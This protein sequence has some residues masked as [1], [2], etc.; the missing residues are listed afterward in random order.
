MLGF[1]TKVPEGVTA[2]WAECMNEESIELQE[3]TETIPA[4]TAVIL[5]SLPPVGKDGL[6]LDF[7]YNSTQDAELD[8]ENM[9]GGTL[10]KSVVAVGENNRAYV[11]QAKDGVA[12]MYWAYANINA[13][14]TKDPENEGKNDNGGHFMNS[15]NRAYLIVSQGQPQPSMFNLRFGFG[16]TTA[17]EKVE[18]RDEKEEIY[19]LTGRKLEGI[20]GVGIYIINGKKMLVK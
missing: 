1:D 4:N 8:G 19:D 11:M 2:Y 3:I 14:G 20:N 17:V 6:D 10:Y 15:A 7:A 18:S 16:G 5:K 12:K 9:L 13:D